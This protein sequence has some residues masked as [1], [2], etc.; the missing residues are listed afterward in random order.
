MIKWRAGAV[1][2]SCTNPLNARPHGSQPTS[3]EHDDHTDEVTPL[4][5]V[6]DDTPWRNTR[7]EATPHSCWLMRMVAERGLRRPV[8]TGYAD[9]LQR[10][11]M[12]A[13]YDDWLRRLGTLMMNWSAWRGDNRSRDED[14]TI[15]NDEGT[16]WRGSEVTKLQGKSWTVERFS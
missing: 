14:R 13:G 10:L 6:G 1:R 12:L 16:R 11:V 9:R 5:A 8:T 15:W 4:S 7:S 2:R 3:T